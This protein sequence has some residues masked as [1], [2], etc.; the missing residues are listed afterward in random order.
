MLSI[1]YAECYNAECHLYSVSFMLS[2]IHNEYHLW[3]A[4]FMKRAANILIMLSVITHN[5]ILRV[6]P[7]PCMPARP[8]PCNIDRPFHNLPFKKVL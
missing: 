8:M 6:F 2:A 5:A 4:L 7:L 1:I 3:C